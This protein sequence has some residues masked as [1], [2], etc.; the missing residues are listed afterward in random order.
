M[1]IHAGKHWE[2]KTFPV[3]WWNAVVKSVADKGFVPVLIGKTV[4]HNVGFVNCNHE[5]AIDL[6]D[7]SSLSDTLWLC[8]NAELMIC[9]DSSPLHMAVTGQCKI[10][11]ICS[12]KHQDYIYHWRKNFDGNIEWAWRM[13]HFNLGGMWDIMDTAPNKDTEQVV[14][15]VDVEILKTWLPK[16]EAMIEWLSLY[17]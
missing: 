9:S 14:D 15:K 13:K 2:S 5:K 4:D 11:F 7:Q 3:E 17:S 10:A 12:A 1:L 6:R 16:P 8:K